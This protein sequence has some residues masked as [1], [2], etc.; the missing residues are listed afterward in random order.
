MDT[1]KGLVNMSTIVEN[2]GMQ[3]DLSHRLHGRLAMF[4]KDPQN[5][6]LRGDCVELAI[7]EKQYDIA[8]QIADK[9]VDQDKSDEQARFER[10]SALMGLHRFDDAL[11]ELRALSQSSDPSPAVLQNIGL[12]N[13]LLGNFSAARAPLE[14]I[15]HQGVRSTDLFRL[16]ISTMHHL[17]DISSALKIADEASEFAGSSDTLAGILGLFYLDA[18]QPQ[19]AAKW[20]AKSL[21][22][23]PDS[24][25]GL[26]VQGTLRAGSFDLKSARQHFE[27]ALSIAPNTGRAWIGLS[28]ISMA[29]S[30]FDLART[31]AEQAVKFM[32][33]H[34]GSW[35]VLAWIHLVQGRLDEAQSVFE[36]ALGLSRNFSE[37][38][39]GLAAIAALRGDSKTAQKLAEIAERLDPNC[40]SA[41]FARSTLQKNDGDVIGAKA[42]L[43]AALSGLSAPDSGAFGRIISKLMGK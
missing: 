2:G 13:Y 27:R 42:T 28:L 38:H 33:G 19:K 35:H 11:V 40:L 8:L 41:K 7:K 21:M 31:Q 39:G 29:T 36:H 17:G 43:F 5:R 37:S 14:A 30:D 15:Y 25:D 22:Q 24:L 9:A 18:S 23:N 34:V 1:T 26:V 10:A 20:S 6:R 16:L 4:A 3:S 12:C 32:P